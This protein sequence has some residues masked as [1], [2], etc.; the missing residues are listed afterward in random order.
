M[1]RGHITVEDGIYMMTVAKRIGLLSNNGRC[2]LR[3]RNGIQVW[4][5]TVVLHDRRGG[6]WHTRAQ[7][8]WYGLVDHF[9]FVPF[10]AYIEDN[11]DDNDYD[12][13]HGSTATSSNRHNA[14][15]SITDSGL[16]GTSV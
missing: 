15:I 11:D 16:N 6:H 7:L 4:A 3:L 9:V 10:P 5:G 12:E 14:H 2:A 8:N 13:N 1:N